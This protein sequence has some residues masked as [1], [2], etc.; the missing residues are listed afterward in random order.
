MSTQIVPPSTLPQPVPRYVPD[1]LQAA[2][3]PPPRPELPVAN[4]DVFVRSPA[5]VQGPVQAIPEVVVRPGDT[6]FD[7]A[8]A[9]GVSLAQLQA[10]NPELF[11]AGFDSRGLSRYPDGSLVY[12][13]DRVR[14]APADGADQPSMPAPGITPAPASPAPAGPRPPANLAELRARLTAPDVD[15]AQTQGFWHVNPEATYNFGH[16][17]VDARLWN[18]SPEGLVVWADSGRPVSWNQ[19]NAMPEVQRQRYFQL[20]GLMPAPPRDEGAGRQAIRTAPP[21]TSPPVPSPPVPSPVPPVPPAAVPAAPPRAAVP[22]PSP[23]RASSPPGDVR[24]RLARALGQN[25][26]Q[27]SRSNC[28]RFARELVLDAGGRDIQHASDDASA[29]GRSIMHLAELASSGRLQPGDVIYVNR[30]PGTDP[31]STNLAN[32]PHWFTF[33]GDGVY[34]DQYGKKSLSEMANFVPGRSLDLIVQPFR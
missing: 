22:Q 3:L 27:G 33:M 16:Q 24:D 7:L 1:M 20:A 9:R 5:V 32:G 13:G 29:R 12:P 18:R 23:R 28:Y 14:L 15:R 34:V 30:K 19:V 6:L 17:L 31:S 21:A 4:R 2:V 11:Q 8:M 10:W 26:Y 25:S